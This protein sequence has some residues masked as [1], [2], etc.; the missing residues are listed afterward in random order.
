[1]VVEYVHIWIGQSVKLLT[2]IKEELQIFAETSVLCVKFFLVV[3]S[4]MR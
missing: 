2:F 3:L 4:P 1:M